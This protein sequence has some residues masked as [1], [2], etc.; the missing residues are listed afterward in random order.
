MKRVYIALAI[1]GVV[2]LVALLPG[3]DVVAQQPACLHGPNESPAEQMR[4]RQALGMARQINSAEVVAQRQTNAYQPLA[5]L[6]RVAAAPAG[7]VV[8]VAV[9]PVGYVFSIK[10][11]TDPCG[12]GY[13]SDQSGQIYNGEALR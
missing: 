7:F 12:F 10:D 11:S 9:D 2:S 1:A 8:Q 5:Q 4:R 3:R 13:F 6:Q